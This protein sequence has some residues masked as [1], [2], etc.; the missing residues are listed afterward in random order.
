MLTHL[1]LAGIG[2]CPFASQALG[3]V[4]GGVVI[5]GVVGKGVVVD[6][7]VVPPPLPH[8]TSSIVVR[9]K[10][11][12]KERPRFIGKYLLQMFFSLL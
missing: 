9:S 7:G 3:V 4:I 10:Q 12:T 2:V 5:G 1:Q 8:P 6:G 11:A